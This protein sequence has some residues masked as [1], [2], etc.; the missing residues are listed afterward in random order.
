[1]GRTEGG[2]RAKGRD[3]FLAR[4]LHSAGPAQGQ[5]AS[6]AATSPA[7]TLRHAPP[8]GGRHAAAAPPPRH[9][10]A[11]AINAP[12]PHA[13]PPRHHVRQNKLHARREGMP[14]GGAKGG[15]PVQD[16]SFGRQPF[17]LATLSHSSFPRGAL[18][19]PRPNPRT[20]QSH[21]TPSQRSARRGK[22]GRASL[23]LLLLRTR[24]G[25]VAGEGHD[26]PRRALCLWRDVA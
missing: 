9:R 13:T 8:R 4:R 1:M 2:G 7:A 23:H 17:R 21:V 12:I 26:V 16:R 14:K 5:L 18:A 6:S 3:R 25:A 22:A 20:D 15:G 10:G 11:N 24:Q 19:P